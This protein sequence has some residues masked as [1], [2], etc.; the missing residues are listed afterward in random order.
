MADSVWFR[1][2]VDTVRPSAPGE[3]YHDFGDGIYFTD[4]YQVAVNYAEKRAEKASGDKLVYEVRFDT[5]GLEI[6]DLRKDTEYQKFLKQGGAS[7]KNEDAMRMSTKGYSEMFQFYIKSN[8]LEAKLQRTDII[9]GPEYFQGGM[10]M[11]ILHKN[12][13]PTRLAALVLSQFRLIW[14][15][16]K[17]IEPIAAPNWLPRV[18][19]ETQPMNVPTTNNPLGRVLGNQNAM[20]AFGQAI[21]DMN[22]RNMDR[23]VMRAAEDDLSGRLALQLQRMLSQGTG[24]L[25]IIAAFQTTWIDGAGQ[26]FRSYHSTYLEPGPDP[27]T[28]ADRF[29]SRPSM[30]VYKPGQELIYYYRWFP[31]YGIRP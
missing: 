2:L 5:K 9:I 28:A 23:N 24:V 26:Q 12:G 18:R 1:G 13:Q 30:D 21:I 6:W 8:K 3:H 19:R 10:Q 15:N 16:G 11:C 31:S 7:V 22:Q 29:H 25:A 14:K 27:D 17:K 20:I 4:T